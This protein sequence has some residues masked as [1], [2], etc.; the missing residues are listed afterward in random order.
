[1]ENDTI[2]YQ[3]LTKADPE[4]SAFQELTRA[5]KILKPSFVDAK[6]ATGIL[7]MILQKRGF[8]LV[9]M[10]NVTVAKNQFSKD[11]QE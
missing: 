3:T 2:E 5:I 4:G 9:K 7:L 10:K 11:F 8:E 1:M 6:G